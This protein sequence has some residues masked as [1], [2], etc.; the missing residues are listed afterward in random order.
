MSI[1]C[2]QGLDELFLYVTG[3][4]DVVYGAATWAEPKFVDAEGKETHACHIKDLKVLEGRHDIDRNLESGVSGPLRI[5]GKEFEHGIHVYAQSKMRIPVPAGQVRFEA[6]MGI[7]DWVGDHGA[8]RFHVTDA[9]RCQT[10]R[11]VDSVRLEFSDGR[12]RREMKRERQDQILHADWRPGRFF[13]NGEAIC[14]SGSANR[15]LQLLAVKKRT[16][17][18]ESMSCSRC[19][20]FTIVPM[21]CRTA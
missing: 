13:R 6:W 14:Q 20:R 17:Q 16:G 15:A 1:Y 3:A 2:R 4:P 19:D 21:T 9:A 5:A 12:S 18:E 11:P 10:T 7:D 8:V